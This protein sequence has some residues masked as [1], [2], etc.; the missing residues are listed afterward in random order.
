MAAMSTTATYINA[1]ENCTHQTGLRTY[2]AAGYRIKLCNLC[3]SR[4]VV[5]PES[6]S[7]VKVAPKANPTSSTP[8]AVPPGL[9]ALVRA[10]A[11]SQG[12]PPFGP[13][14]STSVPFSASSPAY[15]PQRARWPE[16]RPRPTSQ[17][18]KAR[19]PPPPP[20][21]NPTGPPQDQEALETARLAQWRQ[22]VLSQEPERA[23]VSKTA[24]RRR[25]TQVAVPS[26]TMSATQSLTLDEPPEEEITEENWYQDDYPDEEDGTEAWDVHQA[27]NFDLTS[28]QR[29]ISEA[30]MDQL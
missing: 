17:V 13:A 9:V 22:R 1:P 25:P 30:E 10:K 8:L 2:G 20:P 23:A 5:H 26:D 16:E 19:A 27:E 29:G 3:G 7:M 24:P 28:Q 21:F 6:R 4:W 12:A 14:S 11:K 18:P 15:S